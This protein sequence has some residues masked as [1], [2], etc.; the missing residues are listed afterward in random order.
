MNN[1]AH[2]GGMSMNPSPVSGSWSAPMLGGYGGGSPASMLGGMGGLGPTPP[3]GSLGMM[4]HPLMNAG[5]MPQGMIPHPSLNAGMMMS[6]GGGMFHP[7]MMSHPM[8]AG[9]MM[10]PG[11][12][13]H[14]SGGVLHPA[15]SMGFPHPAMMSHLSMPPG[16][17]SFLARAHSASPATAH[18]LFA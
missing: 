3:M 11:G 9:M 8:N 14:P 18:G 12:M 13:L 17:A 7:A 10:S 6:P 4:P 16:V 1:A 15:M 2:M 5:M